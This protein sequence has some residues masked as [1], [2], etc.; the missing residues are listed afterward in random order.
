MSLMI[1]GGVPVLSRPS[2]NPSIS[3]RLC[4]R[5]AEDGGSPILP[6]GELVCPMKS[7]PERKVPVVRMTELQ[8]ISPSP[9][10]ERNTDCIM[11]DR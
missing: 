4:E 8:S 5:P 2:F 1:R 11:I 10:A 7:E 9:P 3:L 6:P